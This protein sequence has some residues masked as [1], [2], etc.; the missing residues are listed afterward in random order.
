MHNNSGVS[1]KQIHNLPLRERVVSALREA[2]LGGELI[3]GQV[4]VESDIASRL[5]VSRAPIR[6][7]IQILSAEGLVESV[8][9]HGTTVCSISQSDVEELYSLRSIL[10]EF[11]IRHIIDQKNADHVKSLHD[12]YCEMVA[13]A[14]SGDL[15]RVSQ[16]D[17]TFH[18]HLIELS[19]HK[20]LAR[21]WHVVS[22]R[23]RQVM[24]LRRIH[25][26]ENASSISQI[27]YS[28]LPIIEAIEQG[29]E[30]QAV[31][32]IQEHIAT[33]GDLIAADWSKQDQT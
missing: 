21:T 33:S 29:N 25:R 13:A 15:G 20:M 10:E 26:Q 8:P 23:V 9:Y 31:A 11:A 7:A 14:E 1:L 22:L 30:E 3:P 32:L 16:I 2:I 19:C 27:A 12:L 6:E 5:G 24:A 4:L 18:D 28:H 17:R